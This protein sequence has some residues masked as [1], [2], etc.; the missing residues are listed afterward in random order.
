MALRPPSACLLE[1]H[2][3][4]DAPASAVLEAGRRPDTDSSRYRI[5]T[6]LRRDTWY[7][8]AQQKDE[9]FLVYYRGTND[10]WDGYG[11]AFIY[12]REPKL[13]KKYIPEI[14]AALQKIGRSF[15]EFTQTDNSCRAG[16]SKLEE[17]KQDLVFVETRVAGGL[18]AQEKNFVNEIAKDFTLVEKEVVK[19]FVAVEKEVVKDITLVEK[20]IVKDVVGV[21]K[22]I[23]KD[24]K[25]IFGFK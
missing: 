20:E 17:A 1:C 21:E 24:V 6:R 23:E 12:S 10:A 13:P 22:E 25:G 15:S 11:G 4:V 19:D 2:C 16:E 3:R 5:V 14:D 18:A 9:Y 8:L 7:V